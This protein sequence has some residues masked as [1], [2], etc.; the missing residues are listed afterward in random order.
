MA[1][2]K[3]IAI[4][5]SSKK[6][7]LKFQ[8]QNEPRMEQDHLNHNAWTVL[9]P[10][11]SSIIIQTW[12]YN[13]SSWTRME[14]ES[15]NGSN[16]RMRE[17]ESISKMKQELKSIQPKWGGMPSLNRKN[18]KETL[19]ML[20]KCPKRERGC[21]DKGTNLLKEGK[22]MVRDLKYGER[23]PPF[24]VFNLIVTSNGEETNIVWPLPLT[25]THPTNQREEDAPPRV[26]NSKLVTCL[27][28]PPPLGLKFVLGT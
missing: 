8:I 22:T 3:T 26:G 20:N 17:Q 5:F 15:K 13:G 16:G 28:G 2:N 10:K 6:L 1:C 12:K 11:I 19:C 4:L 23:N 24:N 21:Q 27:L 18:E 9:P 14:Q 25:F 7:C